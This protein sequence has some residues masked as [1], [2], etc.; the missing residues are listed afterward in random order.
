MLPPLPQADMVKEWESHSCMEMCNLII[1]WN[2]NMQAFPH[3]ERKTP[4][5]SDYESCG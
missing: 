4:A 2:K 1:K 5:G 3:F